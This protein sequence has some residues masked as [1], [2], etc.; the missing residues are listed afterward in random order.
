M[1][2]PV[3]YVRKFD[4]R[5]QIELL[6]AYKPDT[7]KTPGTQVNIAARNGVFVLTEEQRKELQRINREWLETAPIEKS[8]GGTD[9]PQQLTDGETERAP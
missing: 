4:S 8:H 6:R 9:Q 1:G 3:G 7:F 5:L 2:E